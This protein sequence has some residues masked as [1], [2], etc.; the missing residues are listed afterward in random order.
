MN[1]VVAVN[2]WPA[3]FALAGLGVFTGMVVSAEDRSVSFQTS[4]GGAFLTARNGGGSDL[5]ANKYGPGPWETFRLIDIDG[6]KLL[7][8]DRVC[9]RTSGGH[10]V[11]AEMGGGR[12]VKANRTQCGPWETFRIVLVEG[13]G[14]F[15]LAGAQELPRFAGFGGLLFV[16]FQA[17]NGSWVTAEGGGGGNV[18]ANRPAFG[19]WERFRVFYH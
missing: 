15:P 7:N 4:S 16:G 18:N 13:P 3:R 8:H 10:F 19:D 12:E 9:L 2:R 14:G 17:S 6:G 11:V 1:S 5:Y